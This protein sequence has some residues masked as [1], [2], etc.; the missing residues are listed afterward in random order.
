MVEAIELSDNNDVLEQ[1]EKFAHFSK[2]MLDAYVLIDSSGKVVK[3]NQMFCQ[4]VS[5][6]MKALLKSTHIDD[7]L[8]LSL[9]SKKITTDELMSNDIP[10]RMDEVAGEAI[11]SGDMK[12]LIIGVYPFKNS[13]SDRKVGAFLLVR[14][15]TAETNLQGQ[16][17][18]K[19]I[20]S[21]TDPLTG[22]FTRGHFEDYLSGL[23]TQLRNTESEGRQTVSLVMCDIDFFKKVNDRYGHQAGDY[24]LKIVAKLMMD[25]FVRRT[26]AAVMVG[27]NFLLYF[28]TQ[29][30][31]TLQS[32]PIK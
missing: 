28:P 11:N 2:V 3:A 10:Y 6:K 29:T 24:V 16:F 4:L 1:F 32:R 5:V 20:K 9:N 13:T 17:K 30:Q 25:N 21:I 22:L 18:D 26:S 23:V 8:S 7:I 31:A 14:D 12:N 19:A 15:V 27:K